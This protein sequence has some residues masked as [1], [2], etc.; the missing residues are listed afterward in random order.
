VDPL[1][2]DGGNKL[3][4]QDPSNFQSRF[5]AKGS[6]FVTN[7]LWSTTAEELMDFFAEFN[8]KSASV[9]KSFPSEKIPD[10]IPLGWGTV[11]FDTNIDSKHVLETIPPHLD[12][13][14]TVG[15]DITHRGC[16]IDLAV[17]DDLEECNVEAG[18]RRNCS[19]TQS[20][21]CRLCRAC[22]RGYWAQGVSN[23]YECPSV[24]LNL[25]LVILAMLF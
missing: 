13:N 3:C 8:P 17:V 4:E 14:F 7:L 21:K 1:L 16:W 10:R 18:F 15:F 6:L 23:C 25:V 19:Y 12:W 24:V 20:G 11:Y 2:D 5:I 9:K 22:A